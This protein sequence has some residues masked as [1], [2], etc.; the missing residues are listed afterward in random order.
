[1]HVFLF[2]FNCTIVRNYLSLIENFLGKFTDL[3]KIKKENNMTNMRDEEID[4]LEILL[5]SQITLHFVPKNK[6]VVE[7]GWS[8]LEV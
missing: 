3:F 6:T 4:D 2:E 1:M 8:R 7:V 5:T